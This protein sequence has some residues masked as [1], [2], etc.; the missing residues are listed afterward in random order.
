MKLF[1]PI[2]TFML[3]CGQSFAQ[4]ADGG[5]P[6]GE[7]RPAASIESFTQNLKKSEGFFTFFYD[8]K[9]G[10]VYLEVDENQFNKEF[11]Y[12]SAL[13]DGIGNGGAERGQASAE[14]AKFIKVGPK[15]FL[16]EPNLNYRSVNGSADEQHDVENAFAKSI[17]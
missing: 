11:L 14:V 13:V 17:I 2:V 9:T 16:L 8:N 7:N 3:V 15:V 4:R 1:V 6:A 12:F 5:R 10:K